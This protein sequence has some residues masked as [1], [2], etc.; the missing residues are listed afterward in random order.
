MSR[1]RS[2]WIRKLW[3]LPDRDLYLQEF[4]DG[5]RGRLAKGADEYGDRSF[6]RNEF[7]NVTEVLDE[8]LDTA[9]WLFVLWIQARLHARGVRELQKPLLARMQR[10]FL[11][12]V[13]QWVELGL[14]VTPETA[15]LTTV[16]ACC[17]ELTKLAAGAYLSWRALRQRLNRVVSCLTQIPVS[18]QVPDDDKR[19]RRGG[20]T[21]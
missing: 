11:T 21:D 10:E 4:L 8:Q 16:G 18:N 20:Y 19:G 17:D 12:A 7:T 1:R 15:P 2:N 5:V 9:G 14:E 3:Q 6:S 13:T